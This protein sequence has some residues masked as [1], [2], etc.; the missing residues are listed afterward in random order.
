[1]NSIE[2]KLWD[3]IDG[4][5]PAAEQQ[6][7]ALLIEQEEVYRN[8]YNEL[9]QL[10]SEFKAM[11][12]E[13]PSMAFTY[14]VMETIR[15]ENAMKPLK[16]TI[17]KRIITSI[18]AF[19]IFTITAMLVYVLSTVNW[20]TGGSEFK[21]PVELN[22]KAVHLSNFFSGPV[23]KGFLFFDVVMGLFLLDHYLRRKTVA[24]GQ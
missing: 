6:A 19:F 10:N 18:A 14:N 24:K 15:A 2:E 8:K 16:A 23:V 20:S 22:L 17:N 13:E 1:M 4:T 9:L 5:L 11:E 3:Y 12:L 7:I 21:I